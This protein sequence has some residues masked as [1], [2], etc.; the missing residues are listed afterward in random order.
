MELSEI[1][2]REEAE[3]EREETERV[4]DALGSGFEVTLR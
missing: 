2:A 4:I 3:Q 1:K